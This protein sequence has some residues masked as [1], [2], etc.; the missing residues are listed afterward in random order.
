MKHFLFIIFLFLFIQITKS[1]EF[2]KGMLKL[3]TEVGFLASKSSDGNGYSYGIAYQKDLKNNR[4]RVNYRF[5]YGTYT[6]KLANDARDQ[7]F[8]SSD[9]SCNLHIDIIKGG[10]GSVFIGTGLF[11][12][13]VKGLLGS[14][15][16]INSSEYF[17]DFNTGLIFSFGIRSNKPNKRFAFNFMP[18]NIGFAFENTIGENYAYIGMKLEVDIKFLKLEKEM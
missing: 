14:A 7:Y 1:Q 4:F 16:E 13:Q 12:N 10:T 3:S 2:S 18:I 5:L 15:E 6:S 8:T 9:L 11:V 17:R